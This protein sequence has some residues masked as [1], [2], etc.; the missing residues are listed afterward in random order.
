MLWDLET[1]LS[2][3]PLRSVSRPLLTLPHQGSPSQDYLPPRIP[4]GHWFYLSIT[5]P[6]TFLV[7]IT[8]LAAAPSEFAV[9][10]HIVPCCVLHYVKLSF[11]QC[12]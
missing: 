12:W 8:S 5:L 11:G 1:E 6:L 9:I 2:R 10:Y 4:P 3:V 7:A